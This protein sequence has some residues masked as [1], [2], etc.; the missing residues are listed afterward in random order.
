MIVIQIDVAVNTISFRILGVTILLL[1]LLSLAKHIYDV[2]VT[3]MAFVSTLNFFET[4][5]QRTK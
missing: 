2:R 3:L 1:F 5:S 4:L